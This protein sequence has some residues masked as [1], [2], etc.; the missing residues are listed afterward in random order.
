MEKLPLGIQS[1]WE[2]REGK[3]LYIDKTEKIFSLAHS[4]K[5]YFLS[6]PRRFG[7][8]L[9]ISTIKALYQ[10]EKALFKGL[11]IEDQWDWSVVHPVIH[12]SFSSIGYQK[13]GLEQAIDG[14]LEATAADHNIA[15]KSKNI[16]QKFKELLEKTIKK[17]RIKKLALAKN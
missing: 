5:Y 14:V 10:G 16:D 3:Y 6:R 1:F 11:W 7:K 8:S 15:L 4:G 2:L 13:L 9:T 12:I 17:S